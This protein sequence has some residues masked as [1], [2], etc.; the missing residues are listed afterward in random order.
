MQ[1]LTIRTQLLGLALAAMLVSIAG[2]RWGLPGLGLAAGLV[3]AG[4]AWGLRPVLRALRAAECL[5]LAP[6][7]GGFG[8]FK[9]DLL[10]RRGFATENALDMLDLPRDTRLE[11]PGALLERVHPDDLERLRRAPR[12]TTTAQPSYRCEYRIL[13]RSGAAIRWLCEKATVS[14]DRDGR[15]V[16]IVGVILDITGLK[17]TATEL[18]DAGR[19]LERAVRST[20]D[21]LWDIDLLTGTAWYGPRFESLLGYEYGEL[22]ASIAGINNLVHPDDLAPRAAVLLSHLEHGTPYDVEVRI[23][24]KRGHYEWVSSRGQ[25]E[26]DRN[27]K[28]IWIAGSIQIVTDRKRAEQELLAAK[29]AAESANRAK[30]S[31]LANL[32]H[33]I[34]TPMNGVVGMADILADTP[35]DET[36]RE[37]LNII[38]GSAH[39]LL[40]LINDVLDLSKIEAERLEL[41][42]VEF[43]LRD[44]LYETVAATAFQA[45]VKGLELIVDCAPDVPFVVLGDPGRMRQIIMNLVGNSIKFTHEGYVDLRIK[46]RVADD[47]GVILEIHVDDTG[48]GIPAD[49]L[50]RLFHS[51]SQVDSSTTRHYGGSG[52]GL[53]IVK[54]LVELMGGEVRVRSEVGGGSC[55]SVSLPVT[56]VAAQPTTP[57]LGRSRRVLIVDDLAPSRRNIAHKLGMF[58]FATVEAASVAEALGVLE[59]DPGF[60]LVIADELM[61]AAGGLDLLASLRTQPRYAQLPFVLLVL[62]SAE[63]TAAQGPHAPNAVG[64]KP[65]R[66]TVL[67]RLVDS[68]L[69]GDAPGVA[70]LRPATRFS[71]FGAAML[72]ARREFP[73]AK[74]LLVEDNPVNQRVAQRILQKLSVQVTV[75]NN[76]AEAL[77]RLAAMPFDAVLMDCQMPVMDGFTATRRIRESERLR[78]DG[79]HTPIIALTANVMSEDRERC[80]EAGMDAHLGKPIDVTQLANCLERLLIAPPATAAVDLQALRG[81]TDGDAE[82]EQELIATFIASGDKNL[83]EIL[84]A[85]GAKDYETI[86]RRAHSLKSAS[87]NIHALPL[88]QTAAKLE[89][90]VRKHSL[91]EVEGL[92][93]L[94]GSHLSTVNALL[95]RAV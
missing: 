17:T 77:E 43:N 62:F 32:S 29:L 19:R 28:P 61:P 2:A 18:D 46:H 7:T 8:I 20:Q 44:L 34:R 25:A 59:Q 94:L 36:Q 52:L 38:S 1:K 95:R 22:P 78:G 53:S 90:A 35:L 45:S 68:V 74:I 26:H 63:N 79:R 65:L 73:D 60:D 33:E 58:G 85:L 75:A 4:G 50:D 72:P 69:S 82:F 3:L 80:I 81:L 89:A 21:G 55:F 39:A 12:E 10:E 54:R 64:I 93:R 56:V 87:A 84:T 41:E 92:V 42:E 11:R 83:A 48:I 47:G 76:G 66:G 16:R 86:A 51:F 71:T 27:G 70:A 24:H 30:S 37:Y 13:P 23:R 31:F 49:R 9:L 91:G 67:A 57:N 40:A 5:E 6:A 88:A 15:I 14:H